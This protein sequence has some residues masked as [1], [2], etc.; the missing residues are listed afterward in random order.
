MTRAEALEVAKVNRA[1]HLKADIDHMFGRGPAI[2]N[3]LEEYGYRHG[4]YRVGEFSF[5]SDEI[6]GVPYDYTQGGWA[7]L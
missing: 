6:T 5:S 2:K 4:W 3:E 7:F 1:A